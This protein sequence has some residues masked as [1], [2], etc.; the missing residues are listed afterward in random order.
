[1]NKAEPPKGAQAV[2]RAIALLKA[3][4]PEKPK[5]GLAE[6]ADVISLNKTTA[7]RLLA[8]LEWDGLVARDAARGTYQLGPAV[9]AMGSQALLTS[10]LRARIRPT[11]EHLALESG[12]TATFEVKSGDCMLVLDGVLG[13]FRISAS[14]DLGT[15]WP[16]HACSTGKCLLAHMPEA[17]VKLIL[18]R[19]LQGYTPQTITQPEILR[20]ELVHIRERGYAVARE[21]L[22]PDYV[23]VSAPLPGPMGFVEGAVCLGGPVS[24]F[25]GER[26]VAL[27]T[28]LKKAVAQLA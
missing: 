13:S 15:Q 9:I 18:S 7:H 1:M 10:D 20:E 8:A 22:E 4:T 3:F 19:P 2:S 17:E 16:M 26:I 21:E 11:L 28:M 5:M 23:A 27:G 25:D 12:E 24:R 6:L 14:L